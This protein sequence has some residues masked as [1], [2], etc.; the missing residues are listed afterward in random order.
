MCAEI[1]LL[2][3]KVIR[4]FT[5]LPKLFDATGLQRKAQKGRSNLEKTC[6]SEVQQF[7]GDLGDFLRG[8][9]GKEAR[10]I[11]SSTF[12]F[13]V[14][15]QSSRA[16]GN[17]PW[18]W[19]WSRT[20]MGYLEKVLARCQDGSVGKVMGSGWYA[21]PRGSDV[22]IL[23]PPTPCLSHYTKRIA[24]KKLVFADAGRAVWDSTP[25][26][27]RCSLAASQA[28]AMGVLLWSWVR[29][30]GKL[31][32]KDRNKSVQG[33]EISLSS[34]VTAQKTGVMKD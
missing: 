17:T 34:H 16:M 3:S 19:E 29:W 28:K 5:F 9:G 1:E 18:L 22:A 21:R 14:S 30:R 23:S 20:V 27:S 8:N 33:L 12:S 15:F 13:T 25:Q 31:S 10:V 7:L 2:P 11:V 26:A 32:D 24:R 4:P 6:Y